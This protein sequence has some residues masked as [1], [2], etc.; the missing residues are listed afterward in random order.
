[1]VLSELLMGQSEWGPGSRSWGSSLGQLAI[2]SKFLMADPYSSRVHSTGPKCLLPFFEEK[3]WYG[4]SQDS[5]MDP[6]A[7][8]A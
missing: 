2:D 4:Y 6:D 5:N 1:M 7:H 8:G 3:P